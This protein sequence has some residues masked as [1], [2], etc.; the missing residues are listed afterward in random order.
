MGVKNYES[1]IHLPGECARVAHH[2]SGLAQ[3]RLRDLLIEAGRGC[4][5]RELGELARRWAG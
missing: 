4:V 3:S 1:Q 5:P 2:R